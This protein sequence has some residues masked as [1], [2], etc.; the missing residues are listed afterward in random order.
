MMRVLKAR[1]LSQVRLATFEDIEAIK[2]LDLLCRLSV[3]SD[4]VYKSLMLHDTCE[5]VVYVDKEGVVGFCAG[6]FVKPEFEILKIGVRPDKQGCGVGTAMLK[7]V[8]DRAAGIG[9]QECFLEVRW[10]NERAIS[11][12]HK[13]GFEM[14]GVRRKYYRD[15][16]EDARVMR[17]TLG[18]KP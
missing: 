1:P 4:G 10:S 16:V 12:Y 13:E 15:P 6:R 18:K 11:F 2:Q 5:V 14:I 3:W 9:C 17:K 8:L 7:E